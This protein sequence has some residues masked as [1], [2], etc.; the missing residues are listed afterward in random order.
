MTRTEPF[1]RLIHQ[2]LITKDGA[3]MSKSKEMLLVGRVVEKYGSDVFA[4]TSCLW[5]LLLRAATGDQ[6]ISGIAVLLNVFSHGE[7]K[8][9]R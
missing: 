4:C 9:C 8:I 1:R 5:G 6:G 3:K 2:G 7:G